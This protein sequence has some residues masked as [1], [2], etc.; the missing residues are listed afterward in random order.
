[1]LPINAKQVTC[2]QRMLCLKNVIKK[3]TCNYFSGGIFRWRGGQKTEGYAKQEW[4]NKVWVCVCVCV[5]KGTR[6]ELPS[7][8]SLQTCIDACQSVHYIAQ[9]GQRE[10]KQR[11]A[12]RTEAV[13]VVH[14]KA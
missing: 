4:L 12:F 13:V 9:G 7:I 2:K 10:G 1:M 14:L 11:S 3:S 6:P 8:V 5:L